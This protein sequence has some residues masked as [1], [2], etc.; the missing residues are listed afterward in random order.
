[1]DLDTPFPRNQ[2]VSNLLAL[3]LAPFKLLLLL[4]LLLFQPWHHLRDIFD[5]ASTIAA[6]RPPS[7]QPVIDSDTPG[8][9]T[10]C[11]NTH[12][13]TTSTQKAKVAR[14]VPGVEQG[15]REGP[16]R[17]PERWEVRQQLRHSFWHHFARVSAGTT[18]ARAG[19]STTPA[20]AAHATTDK[21]KDLHS[22]EI[23]YRSGWFAYILVANWCL[24]SD[25]MTNSRLQVRDGRAPAQLDRRYRRRVARVG[26]R[27]PPSVKAKV[28]AHQ[29]DGL[30]NGT[31]LF[32][33]KRTNYRFCK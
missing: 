31:G 18:P 17:R 23:Q 24:R 5:R 2:P 26:G 25:V 33:D 32:D 20:R 19:V 9:R 28:T 11:Q 14:P 13:K 15:V 21:T 3:T 27:L 10:K 8:W 16:P 4:L 7:T 1:L 29:R 12:I 6:H 22:A 30:K